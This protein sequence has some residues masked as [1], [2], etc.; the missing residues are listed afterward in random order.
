MSANKDLGIK[1]YRPIFKTFAIILI[2]FFLAPTHL[3]LSLYKENE[4]FRLMAIFASALIVLGALFNMISI[5][6]RAIST[7]D[8][9]IEK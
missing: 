9:N 8:L 5:S 4:S 1:F 3:L 6:I 2:G 7:V